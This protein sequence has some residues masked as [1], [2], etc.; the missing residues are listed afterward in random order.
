MRKTGI[1]VDKRKNITHNKGALNKS[2]LDGNLTKEQKIFL[3]SKGISPENGASLGMIKVLLFS[4][5]EDG[6][7][8]SHF[9]GI[10]ISPNRATE[11]PVKENELWVCAVEGEANNRGTAQPLYRIDSEDIVNINGKTETLAKFMWENSPEEIV[12]YLGLSE[13]VARLEEINSDLEGLKK[14]HER[15]KSQLSEK[16]DADIALRA[17]IE[18]GFRKTEKKL[19]GEHEAALS[20]L[21]VEYGEKERQNLAEIEDLNNKVQE[22]ENGTDSAEIQKLREEIIQLSEKNESLEEKIKADKTEMENK[23]EEFNIKSATDSSYY[24]GIIESL[25]KELNEY[26]SDVESQTER[27][28]H[29][30]H[31]VKELN[32]L[33][34]T[35]KAEMERKVEELRTANRS[36]TDHYEA[37]INGLEVE[38]A[39]YRNEAETLRE[40]AKPFMPGEDSVLSDHKDEEVLMLKKELDVMMSR[41]HVTCQSLIAA[42]SRLEALDRETDSSAVRPKLKPMSGS[43]IRLSADEFKCS[44][45]NEGKY[46][47]KINVD[48]TVM[49]FVPD[50]YG[51]A[52][53]RNGIIHVPGL[54]RIEV[55]GNRFGELKWRM[56]NENTLEVS[57]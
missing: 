51:I 45:I 29:L 12:K 55:L 8:I 14:E 7:L 56:V 28:N 37:K 27:S 49:R 35:K 25:N 16:K 54:N 2:V 32:N 50:V 53:C 48:G 38:L 6:E 15:L 24:E 20:K 43:V 18:E 42:N 3:G 47:V 13:D 46:T 34:D 9:D 10:R 36:F 26:R 1:S 5:G 31:E 41:Y 4:K 39:R 22:L 21:A 40:E 44:L 17:E 57:I 33:L 30:T 23:V 11:T 19:I 52:E